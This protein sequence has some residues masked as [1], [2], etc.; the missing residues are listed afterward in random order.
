MVS[1]GHLIL[2]TT[3]CSGDGSTC[4]QVFQNLTVLISCNIGIL[5]INYGWTPT[6]NKIKEWEWIGNN[7]VGQHASFG[8]LGQI[9]MTVGSCFNIFM[10]WAAELDFD[11]GGMENTTSAWNEESY[12]LFFLATFS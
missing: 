7:G 5:K 1:V 11:S 9:S 12:D 2:S 6:F 4:I 8:I 10:K 3:V